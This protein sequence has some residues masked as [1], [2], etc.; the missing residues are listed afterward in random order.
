M[1]CFS[2]IYLNYFN[3][4]KTEERRRRRMMKE[5]KNDG[6]RNRNLEK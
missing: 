1:V 4:K 6:G 2:D 5:R 3:A